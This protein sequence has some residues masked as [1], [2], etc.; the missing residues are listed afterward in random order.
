MK[1]ALLGTGL[2]RKVYTPVELLGDPPADDPD[3]ALL[4]NSFFEPRSPQVIATLK[5]YVYVGEPA[6]GHGPR[7]RAR[8]RPARAVVAFLGS[9]ITA[10]RHD[11]ACGPEDIAPTLAALLGLEYRVEEGQRVLAEALAGTGAVPRREADK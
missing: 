10:G 2:V 9:G 8:L 6:G 4:R 7:H 5:P 1:E 3:F 11:A